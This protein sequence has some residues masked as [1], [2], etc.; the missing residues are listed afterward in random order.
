MF[1]LTE[2][3]PP[4]TKSDTGF[5]LCTDCDEGFYQLEYGR[6]TCIECQPN[7]Y[8]IPQCPFYNTSQVIVSPSDTPS[9]NNNETST[10]STSSKIMKLSIIS[11][12]SVGK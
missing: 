2:Y 5:P 8:D 1:D 10:D 11:F 9:P 7:D 4:G 6:K 3:C 12:G